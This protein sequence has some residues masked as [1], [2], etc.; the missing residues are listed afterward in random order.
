[1]QSRPSESGN[2]PLL[3]RVTDVLSGNPFGIMERFRNTFGKTLDCKKHPDDGIFMPQSLAYHINHDDETG[4]KRYINWMQVLSARKC[5]GMEHGLQFYYA[6]K[7]MDGQPELQKDLLCDYTRA[8]SRNGE[9]DAE[10][11]ANVVETHLQHPT[12]FTVHVDAGKTFQ[13]YKAG[14]YNFSH[15]IA[16]QSIGTNTE[17]TV[18]AVLAYSGMIGYSNVLRQQ[19]SEHNTATVAV[20]LDG[21]I[22]NPNDT[23][24]FIVRYD[25]TLVDVRPISKPG[26]AQEILG[27]KQLILIDDTRSTGQTLTRVTEF[28]KESDIFPSVADT[29]CAFNPLNGGAHKNGYHHKVPPTL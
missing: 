16:R 13:V 7:M 22:D 19:L 18:P 9:G 1:M 20:I 2:S 27:D 10:R 12:L 25:T 6:L 8:I 17:N 28:C 5:A 23:Y 26:Q 4:P 11:T 21:R 29:R 24:G 3:R 14:P 15:Q